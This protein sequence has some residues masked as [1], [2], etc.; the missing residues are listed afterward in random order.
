MFTNDLKLTATLKDSAKFKTNR[1]Y[2][3]AFYIYLDNYQKLFTDASMLSKVISSSH[4]SEI[5]SIGNDYYVSLYK[6][7]SI[8]YADK[9]KKYIDLEIQLEKRVDKGH[10]IASILFSP[11][12][13]IYDSF[14][15]GD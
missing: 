6:I 10:F 14:D 7:D 8:F 2:F 15:L 9:K 4:E 11:L 1:A 5:I 3:N 12:D 13:I